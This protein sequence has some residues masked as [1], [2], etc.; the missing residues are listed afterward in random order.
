MAMVSGDDVALSI[1][2]DSMFEAEQKSF[3][4]VNAKE[5]EVRTPGREEYRK[6]K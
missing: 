3:Q 5:Q 6:Y 2:G 1:V 4:L